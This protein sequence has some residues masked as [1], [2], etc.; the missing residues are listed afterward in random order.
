MGA[1]RRTVVSLDIYTHTCTY[2]QKYNC[3]KLQTVDKRGRKT[4]PIR[5]SFTLNEGFSSPSFL[6]FHCPFSIV[7]AAN[8]GARCNSRRISYLTY[9]STYVCIRSIPRETGCCAR[10]RA[11]AICLYHSRTCRHAD[12]IIVY[13]LT[14][15]LMRYRLTIARIHIL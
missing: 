10:V 12:A 3:L 4:F 6:E 8:N 13:T 7:R 9:P 11:F 5:A 14:H 1:K 15:N 2:T